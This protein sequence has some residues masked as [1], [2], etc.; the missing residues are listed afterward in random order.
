MSLFEKVLILYLEARIRIWIRIKVIGRIRIR[1]KEASRIRIRINVMRIH[2][3]GRQTH[4]AERDK[5]SSL[6][7]IRECPGLVLATGFW[8]R[9]H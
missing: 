7:I 3:I 6:S 1:I 9:H 5:L 8:S 2:N 4:L